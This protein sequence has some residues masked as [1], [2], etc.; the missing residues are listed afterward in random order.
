MAER[1]IIVLNTMDPE[2]KGVEEVVQ[3][4]PTEQEI[5]L[6]SEGSEG[7]AD[8]EESTEIDY[9]A[10]LAKAQE[11]AENYKKGM[12]NAKDELKKKKNIDPEE[13]VKVIGEV[14]DKK[15]ESFQGVL[16]KNTFENTLASL[17]S[18]KAKQDLIK[19][20]YENSIVKSGTDP[21]SIANDLENALLIADKKIFIKEKKELAIAA[22]N[23]SQIGNTGMGG[24]D[25]PGSTKKFFT[26][27]QLIDLRKRGFTDQMIEN[28][29]KAMMKKP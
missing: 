4:A 11:N 24:S 26:D 19:F 20:H 27:Q 16:T 5:A 23:R 28:L 21:Q 3:E 17:T 29:K 2:E 22:N 25:K 6:E 7:A 12:L 8:P 14:F 15:L 18:N 13:L 9:V 1:A 10:A